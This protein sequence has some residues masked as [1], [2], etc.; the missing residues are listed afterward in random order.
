[1]LCY[2]SYEMNNR[3]SSKTESVH[4]NSPKRFQNKDNIMIRIITARCSGG[5]HKHL[6]SKIYFRQNCNYS[7]KDWMPYCFELCVEYCTRDCI[8]IGKV[9]VLYKKSMCC[10]SKCSK[11]YYNGPKTK[12]AYILTH[13]IQTRT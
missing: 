11:K 10:T 12:W 5:G 3:A 1:M 6:Y 8:Y 4:S 9:W 7:I 13:R 2:K